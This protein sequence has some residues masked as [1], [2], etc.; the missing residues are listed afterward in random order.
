MTIK[1]Y[2]YIIADLK[3]QLGSYGSN[4]EHRLVE[5][6]NASL[7]LNKVGLD[8]QFLNLIKTLMNYWN[9]CSV[10]IHTE[11]NLKHLKAKVESGAVYGKTAL[12]GEKNDDNR[13]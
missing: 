13:V 5:M 11:T 7:Q 2:E 1:E 12:E 4:I 10:L 3:N 9:C 6:V 8:A